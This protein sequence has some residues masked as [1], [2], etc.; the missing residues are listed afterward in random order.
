MMIQSKV[1][2]RPSHDKMPQKHAAHWQRNP[3]TEAWFQQSCCYASLL[4]SLLS[5]DAPTPVE[6]M[7]QKILCFLPEEFFF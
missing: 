5:T 2:Q 6:N 7:K 1:P 3:H 4:K